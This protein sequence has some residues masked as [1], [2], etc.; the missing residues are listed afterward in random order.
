MLMS[1]FD[2]VR[3]LENDSTFTLVMGYV[4]FATGGVLFLFSIWTD[5]K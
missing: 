2:M 3:F 1:I 5:K 4:F